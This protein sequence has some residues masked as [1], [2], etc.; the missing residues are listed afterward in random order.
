MVAGN[1]F[2]SGNGAVSP[3]T[4]FTISSNTIS[5]TIGRQGIAVIDGMIGSIS[6]NTITYNGTQN[7]IDI[8]PDS[9]CG[10][11]SIS[12]TDNTVTIANSAALSAISAG[13]G[14]GGTLA[15]ITVTGNIVNLANYAAYGIEISTPTGTTIISDNAISNFTTYGIITFDTLTLVIQN[16]AII[17]SVSNNGYGIGVKNFTASGTT[18]TISTNIVTQAGGSGIGLHGGGMT[19]SINSNFL[20]AVTG[21]NSSGIGNE[22]ND[23]LTSVSA[24]NNVIV[25]FRTGLAF[26]YNSTGGTFNAY[27]NTVEMGTTGANLQGFVV[28]DGSA[29]IKNNIFDYLGAVAA[30]MEVYYSNNSATLTADYNI[31]H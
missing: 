29:I 7:A 17:G 16:N 2:C 21:S 12:I 31:Y 11:S 6:A 13:E 1:N 15:N 9:G 26:G 5:G 19:V 20:T 3:S 10:A 24:T 25:G 18:A 4:N 28:F 8:E 22:N 23:S 14:S 27:N 30:I